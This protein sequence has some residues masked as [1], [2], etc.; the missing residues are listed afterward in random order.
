MEASV[1]VVERILGYRFRNWKLLEEALTHSSFTEDVSYERLEFIGDSVISLAISNYLFLAYPRLDPGHLSTLRAANISTEKLA[2]VAVRHG[3]HRFVRHNA[4]ALMDQ[5]ERFVDAVALEN[6]SVVAHGGSVKAPKV[7]ADIVES[8]AGAIY[9][10]VGYDLEELWKN[11]RG[12]LEPIVTP[13]DLEQQPQPVTALFEICQKRGKNVEI[14]QERNETECIANVFVD[15]EF[16][17]S[18]TSVQKDLAKLEA[19][20]IALNRLAYLI[21]LTS[22]SSTMSFYPDEDGN[23]IIEAAKHRLYELCESKKWPKP[24]YRIVKDS[25]PPHEKRFVCAVE[26]TIEGEEERI[27]QMSGYEKS[28][29]KDAQNTAASLML[30]ALLES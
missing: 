20:K 1:N 26:I 12:I 30:M 16:I 3:L 8:V 21:P 4:P 6:D 25:G 14:Q 2:R 27:L 11:F 15:G 7:L 19:A 5:V 9:F 23:M 17:A 18:A 29:L 28:R 10:D 24:V 13:G 22:S